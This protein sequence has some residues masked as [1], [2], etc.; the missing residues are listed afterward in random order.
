MRTQGTA[1]RKRYFGHPDCCGA[2][3]G[4]YCG[5]DVATL[6]GITPGAIDNSYC[7]VL[8][9]SNSYTIASA[10][11][12]MQGL[13]S[14]RSPSASSCPEAGQ[15]NGS[16]ADSSLARHRYPNITTVQLGSDRESVL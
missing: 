3:A 2:G 16:R 12:F 6:D 14:P 8:A 7:T 9:A 1:F 5:Y 13:Y 10:A 4:G 11:A 15:F